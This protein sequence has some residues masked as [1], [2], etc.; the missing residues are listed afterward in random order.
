MRD[1]DKLGER[2]LKDFDVFTVEELMK[3]YKGVGKSSIHGALR[4][5][6][7][8]RKIIFLWRNRRNPIYMKVG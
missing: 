1:L 7:T 3:N 8:K 4:K 6:R 2:I 5:L